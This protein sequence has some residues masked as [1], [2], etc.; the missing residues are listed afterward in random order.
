M[1]LHDCTM[2]CRVIDC[3]KLSTGEFLD[4]RLPHRKLLNLAGHGGGEAL[5]E[6]DVAWDL[7]VRD[8]ILTEL[9]DTLLVEAGTRL[10]N[11]PGTEFFA[12]LNVRHAENLDIP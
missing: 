2:G 5:Y 7:V 8:P 3:P 10:R 12:I 9:A 11:D 4:H 6:P 1:T